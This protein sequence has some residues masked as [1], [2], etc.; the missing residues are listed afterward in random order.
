MNVST[1][2]LC[3]LVVFPSGVCADGDTRHMTR[4]VTHARRGDRGQKAV[5]RPLR[6]VSPPLS[7]TKQ[8]KHTSMESIEFALKIMC[9]VYCGYF[10]LRYYVII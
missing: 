4:H 10:Y 5:T 9:P 3:V 8:C 7:S 2:H 6:T 1:L